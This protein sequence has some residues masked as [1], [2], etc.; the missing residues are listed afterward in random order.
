MIRTNSFNKAAGI[1]LTLQ[2]K[3]K[4][5]VALEDT[6]VGRLV[7][8]LIAPNLFR[9]TENREYSVAELTSMLQQTSE[10]EGTDPYDYNLKQF[11]DLAATGV[12][13][14]IHL[15]KNIALPVIEDITQKVEEAVTAETVNR[16]LALNIVDDGA[17]AI[18]DSSI[19]ENAVERYVDTA[20]PNVI[21]TAPYHDPR[22]SEQIMELMKVGLDKFDEDIKG[23][24]ARVTGSEKAIDLYSRVFAQGASA[25]SLEN[26]IGKDSSSYINAIIVF[27]IARG[28]TQDL[29]EHIN[30]NKATYDNVMS[31]IICYSALVVK[32]AIATRKAGSV[33]KYL[34]ESFPPANEEYSYTDPSR[35]VIIV[36]KALYDQFLESGGT[37]EVV[38][39]A[40]LSDRQ[41]AYDDLLA[42]KDRYTSVYNARVLQARSDNAS[43]GTMVMRRALK[44]CIYDEINHCKV[45]ATDKGLWGG[46]VLETENAFD[47]ADAL[48]AKTNVN[49]LNNIYLAV[50][51]IVLATFFQSTDVEQLI[52]YI[53]AAKGFGGNDDIQTSV[54]VA[55]MDYI[56]NW[57]LSQTKITV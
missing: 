42:N 26:I 3:G 17:K 4:G 24:M 55:I 25:G 34:V 18:L 46:I 6:P 32:Q 13:R 52:N 31:A 56:I 36:N 47:I 1:S 2:E 54:N 7:A 16:G 15:T 39:G 50:K 9:L 23:W 19:L 22:S 45:D 30:L 8:P 33:T 51:D 29:D 21:D 37:P 12:R 44:T 11:V 14:T 20:L 28:L 27:L 10:V 38:M 41:N 35:G 53:E 40:Y 57:F 49:D 5:L 48:I 43:R